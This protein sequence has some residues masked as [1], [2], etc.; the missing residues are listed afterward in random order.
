MRVIVLD[1]IFPLLSFHFL[2]TYM[3]DTL[4]VIRQ[5]Y[6]ILTALYL[7]LRWNTPHIDPIFMT[8]SSICAGPFYLLSVL[9]SRIRIVLFSKGLSLAIRNLKGSDVLVPMNN[10]SSP[11]TGAC[12]WVHKLMWVHFPTQ[13][14][15]VPSTHKVNFCS[16]P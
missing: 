12:L 16:H 1:I 14:C 10:S 9:D 2:S 8:F 7:F 15:T 3:S 5:T 4:S 13:T 6:K 11:Q